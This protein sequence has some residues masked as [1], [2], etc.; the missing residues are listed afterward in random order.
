MLRGP[1]NSEFGRQI[2]NVTVRVVKRTAKMLQFTV[3]NIGTVYRKKIQVDKLLNNETEGEYVMWF[4]ERIS[5]FDV[6]NR[7]IPRKAT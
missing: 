7:N 1:R 5:T 6:V 2:D 3:G 4:S